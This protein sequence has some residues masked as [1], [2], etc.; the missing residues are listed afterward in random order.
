MM[1][2]THR[3]AALS[4]FLKSCRARV[5]P[6][7]VGLPE[8]GRRRTPGL[9]RE[10]VAALSG[11]SVT[12]YT[13]LEQ[14][15]D[16]RVSTEVLERVRSTLQLS[17]DEREYLFELAQNRPPPLQRGDVDEVTPSMLRMLHNL[18]L[19]AYITTMRWDVVAWNDMCARV[20]R[21]YS[22]W[23][24]GERNALRILFASDQY[25]D[26]PGEY[27]A[28]ARRLTSKLKVDYSQFPGDPAL[29]VLVSEMSARYPIFARFWNDAEVKARSESESRVRHAE[30][31]LIRFDHS[32]YMPEGRPT[33][34]VVIF[35]PYDA[36]SA[37]KI[38]KLSR[39]LA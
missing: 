18:S 9:R 14:G 34:R 23:P 22:K 12:W 30:L 3:R 37:E 36:E 29:E 35:A 33:L 1:S 17:S 15:R 4:R 8:P 2:D 24:E 19:P 26:D 28:M 38:E 20:L 6:A 21:D 7:D 16:V 11:V 13:W 25:K 5:T 31:G 32:S 27:E 39:K 10:D